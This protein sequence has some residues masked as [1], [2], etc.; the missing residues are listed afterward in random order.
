[1]G[2]S[3]EFEDH[4]ELGE[5][6]VELPGGLHDGGHVGDAPEA[7]GLPDV[8]EDDEGD[9]AVGV[10]AA[11]VEGVVQP[12]VEGVGGPDFDD[13]G[14]GAVGAGGG[15]GGAVEEVYLV[16][17]ELVAAGDAPYAVDVV[18]DPP[19]EDALHVGGGDADALL[20]GVPGDLVG[21]VAEDGGVEF[22]VEVELVEV[23]VG[24][25]GGEGAFGLVGAAGG[26]VGVVVGFDGEGDVGHEVGGYLVDEGAGVVEG[27]AAFLASGG[28]GP[29]G[30]GV[31]GEVFGVGAEAVGV[32]AL[33]LLGDCQVCDGFLSFGV[34]LGKCGVLIIVFWPHPSPLTPEAHLQPLEGEGTGPPRPTA[35]RLLNSTTAFVTQDSS[36]PFGMTWH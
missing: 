4:G 19:Y 34:F 13:G 12:D 3:G 30:A 24:V 36:L 8:G 27:E 29:L 5:G 6:A 32:E 23:V 14:V 25:D 21:G 2:F 7:L 26:F 9:E 20:V 35:P 33:E 11:F 15:G 22:G 17:G 1:M 31:E 28:A 18:A 10:G 16:G